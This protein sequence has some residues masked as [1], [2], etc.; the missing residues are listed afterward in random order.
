MNGSFKIAEAKFATVD[1]GKMVTEGVNNALGDIKKKV[2]PLADKSIQTPNSFRSQY[3]EI[4]SGFTLKG[5]VF[6]APDFKTVSVEKEG[7]DLE[8][9]TVAD[10]VNDKLDADW[11]VIDTYNITKA[12]DVS[13]NMNGVKVDHILAEGSKPV[14]FPVKVGCQLSAPCYQYDQVAKHLANIA[15]NNVRKAAG[16]RVNQEIDK[17]KARAK[18]ELEKKKKEA[19]K[20]IAK[21]KDEA[22]AKASEKAKEEADKLKKKFGF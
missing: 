11:L 2:P 7:I 17:A 3:D 6:T 22:K 19:N 12:R 13:V 14:S 16:E 18:E 10:L 20:K 4:S 1:V 5:G 9:R 15:L 21:K 8:G